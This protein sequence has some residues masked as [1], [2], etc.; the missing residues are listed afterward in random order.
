MSAIFSMAVLNLAG[1]QF[2]SI[3]QLAVCMYGNVVGNPG[4]CNQRLPLCLRAHGFINAGQNV[5]FDCRNNFIFVDIKIIQ[6]GGSVV[7]WID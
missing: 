2:N 3:C 7:V 4:Q 6:A 5:V 1:T